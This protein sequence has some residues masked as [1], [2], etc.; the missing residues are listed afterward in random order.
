M[1][2]LML[3]IMLIRLSLRVGLILIVSVKIHASSCNQKD[4]LFGRRRIDT[5]S[6]NDKDMEIGVIS[7]KIMQI[8]WNI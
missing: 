7:S 3:T 1:I 5:I 6:G 8:K 4:S 2:K